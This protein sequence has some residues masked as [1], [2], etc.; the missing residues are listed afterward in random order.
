MGARHGANMYSDKINAICKPFWFNYHEKYK[1]LIV[2][3]SKYELIYHNSVTEYSH[4][5]VLQLEH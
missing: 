1:W 4:I 3:R 5:C 2:I